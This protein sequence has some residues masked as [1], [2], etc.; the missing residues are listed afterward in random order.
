LEVY[1]GEV[2]TG[3]FNG[4]SGVDTNYI[5]VEIGVFTDGFVEVKGNISEGQ[6]VVVPR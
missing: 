1:E 5:A 3:T 6:V 2:E 4:E